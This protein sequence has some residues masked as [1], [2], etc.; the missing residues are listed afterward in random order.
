MPERNRER[1]IQNYMVSALMNVNRDHVCA[2]VSEGLDPPT[3]NPD[4]E[5]W[6]AASWHKAGKESA[7]VQQAK[8][9]KRWPKLDTKVVTSDGMGVIK[10]K[11]KVY[12]ANRADGS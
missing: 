6:Y 2:L 11:R 3:V 10:I 7:W 12:N 4:V 5:G 9:R 8:L 1:E